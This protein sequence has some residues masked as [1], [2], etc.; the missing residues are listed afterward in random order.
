MMVT[1][2]VVINFIG[3]SLMKEDKKR[4]RKNE[5]R[6]S[7]KNL[8]IIA[9]LFGATGMTVGMNV[10]RH[11]TKHPSFKLG[12]PILVVVEFVFIIYLQNLFA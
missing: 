2:L 6:I 12:L 11:K 10:F 8:W 5:Y 4:A 7:E 1:Y 3:Y 9:W